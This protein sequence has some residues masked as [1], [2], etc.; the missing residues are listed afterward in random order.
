MYK[1]PERIRHPLPLARAPSTS[2]AAD[3]LLFSPLRLRSGLVLREPAKPRHRFW[4][5]APDH[6]P[7]EGELALVGARPVA[8]DLALFDAVALLHG[9]MPPLGD[10]ILD[11]LASVLVRHDGD[12]PLVLIIA[13]KLHRA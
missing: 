9:E 3:S 12:A 6:V 11:R 5:T 10:E 13:A 8:D 2:E 7:P 1:P 4:Y